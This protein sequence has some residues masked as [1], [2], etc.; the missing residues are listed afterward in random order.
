MWGWREFFIAK[1]G[2]IEYNE[3]DSCRIYAEKTGKEEL[4]NMQTVYGDLKTAEKCGVCAGY[5]TEHTF[6]G[7]GKSLS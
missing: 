7:G 5:K 4:M 6:A 2:R 3:D 1:S